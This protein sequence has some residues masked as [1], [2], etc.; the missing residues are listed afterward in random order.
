MATGTPIV[1]LDS[2]GVA[3]ACGDAALYASSRRPADL[4]AAIV[5]IATDSESSTVR[6]AAGIARAK[7]LTWEKT[8]S[9]IS[10]LVAG[11]P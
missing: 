6:A 10:E 1:A 2:V 9:R 3:E 5:T 4:A 11:L 8:W 7:N